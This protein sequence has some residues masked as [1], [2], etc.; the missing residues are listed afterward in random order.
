MSSWRPRTAYIGL[1]DENAEATGN[2]IS[3]SSLFKMSYSLQGT[4]SWLTAYQSERAESHEW[5]TGVSPCTSFMTPERILT[6]QMILV[7]RAAICFSRQFGWADTK[8]SLATLVSWLCLSNPVI[9]SGMAQSRELR[10]DHG[11]IRQFA[12]TIV[13]G[14][15][16]R[17]GSY[18][19][20][21]DETLGPLE[22]WLR[23]SLVAEE[24]SSDRG[25]DGFA[26]STLGDWFWNLDRA[27][28]G[29]RRKGGARDAY[30]EAALAGESLQ[31]VLARR[32]SP[33]T[34]L[35][36]SRCTS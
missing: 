8:S 7:D 3:P 6:M 25:T 34:C 17:G 33:E 15:C 35:E 32:V 23:Q 20:I 11:R 26:C 21:D 22:D 19:E 12:K 36:D 5:G 16:R 13:G 4:A 31:K 24:E 10:L 1:A 28:Y 2:A 9:A 29:P 27:I 30:R 18:Q 14:M